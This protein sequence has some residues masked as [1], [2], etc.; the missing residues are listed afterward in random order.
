MA[1]QLLLDSRF[2]KYF[3]VGEFTQVLK[4]IFLR[5]FFV[6]SLVGSLSVEIETEVDVEL[7][8]ANTAVGEVDKSKPVVTATEIHIFIFITIYRLTNKFLFQAGRSSSMSV[9]NA[10]IGERSDLVNVTCANN[11]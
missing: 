10:A 6:K 2:F 3:A 9:T 7:D 1:L 11:G 8:C 4:E 5:L